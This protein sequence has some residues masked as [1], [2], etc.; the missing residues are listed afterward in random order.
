MECLSECEFQK[1]KEG[2]FYCKYYDLNLE[3]SVES[4]KDDMKII[5]CNSCAE[6]DIIGKNSVQEKAKK[7]KYRIGLVMDSFY[8][9]KYDMESE[10]TE[11]YRN[12]KDLEN[13]DQ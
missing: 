4:M 13:E 10:I 6:G 8:S 3:Y 7:I 9:F 1:F 12:L 5:R 11:I 2:K